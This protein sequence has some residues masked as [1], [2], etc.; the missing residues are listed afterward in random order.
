MEVIALV[1]AEGDKAGC[2]RE[3]VEVTAD[4]AVHIGYLL[5]VKVIRCGEGEVPVGGGV[6]ASAEAEV[7]SPLAVIFHLLFVK[8]SVAI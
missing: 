3:A 6:Y 8:L 4:V 5:E 1:W 7:L 2:H